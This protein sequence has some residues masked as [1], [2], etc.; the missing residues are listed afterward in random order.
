MVL[1]MWI[2]KVPSEQQHQGQLSD[3]CLLQVNVPPSQPEP[4][5]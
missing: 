5:A 1:E 3:A 4:Q 2:A